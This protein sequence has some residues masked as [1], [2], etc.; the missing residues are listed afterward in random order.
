MTPNPTLP[1]RR[2][3]AAA[4]ALLMAGGILTALVGL[5]GHASRDVWLMPVPW[6]HGEVMACDRLGYG[7]A[8][9]TCMREL[10]AVVRLRA[11]SANRLAGQGPATDPRAAAGLPRPQ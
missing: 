9:E 6:L 7:Q 3:W 5:F 1:R 10:R 11:D 4:A 8:R 2:G